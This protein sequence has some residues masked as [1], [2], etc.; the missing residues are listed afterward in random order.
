VG[1]GQRDLM[2]AEGHADVSATAIKARAEDEEEIV[3]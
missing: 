3:W 1:W 2:D